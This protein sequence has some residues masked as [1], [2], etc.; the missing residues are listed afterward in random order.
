MVHPNHPQCHVKAYRVSSIQWFVIIILKGFHWDISE[1][2]LILTGVLFCMNMSS[3]IPLLLEHS[4][5]PKSVHHSIYRCFQGDWNTRKLSSKLLGY[6]LK[7]S[8]LIQLQ[9]TNTLFAVLYFIVNNKNTLLCSSY[10]MRPHGRSFKEVI[11]WQDNKPLSAK[12]ARWVTRYICDS[13]CFKYRISLQL[14]I[15]TDSCITNFIR[16]HTLR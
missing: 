11:Q 6:Y 2:S 13:P 16:K 15:L 10:N 14:Y 9:T 12:T 5:C 7:D 8:L 3:L 4:T 1:Q